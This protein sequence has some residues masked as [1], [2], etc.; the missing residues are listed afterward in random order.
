M[1]TGS[2]IVVIIANAKVSAALI[3]V[4][5]Q[6][7]FGGKIFGGPSIGQTEF[8]RDA[9]AAA[10]G[11]TFPTLVS[12]RNEESFA[13]KYEERT[14]VRPDYRAFQTYDALNLL[15]AAIRKAGLNRARIRDEV[16]GLS[17]WYGV[18]GA[19]TWDALGQNKRPVVL[20]TIANHRLQ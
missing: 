3:R 5:K 8:L 13:H 2:E 14:G 10:A 1:A 7:H 9:G 17:P 11:V 12:L 19:V 20:T 15:I 18:S 4:L 6:R 16:R